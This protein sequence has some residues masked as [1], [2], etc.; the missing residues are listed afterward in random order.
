MANAKLTTVNLTDGYRTD[1]HNRD[2]V[3]HADE[4]LDVGGTDTAPTPMETALGALGSCVA[5]TMKMYAQRKGWPLTGVE[6]KLS[7]ERLKAVDYAPYQGDAPF[8]HR[9]VKQIELYG[10]LTPEQRQRITEIGEK[11][12]V[13]RLITEPSFIETELLTAE[14][15]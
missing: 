6:V 11:C 2:F 8:V 12:P 13:A 15:Q 7:M 5:V 1:I 9:L 14:P 4:P 10:D 3:W